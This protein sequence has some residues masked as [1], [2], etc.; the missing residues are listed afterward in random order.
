MT[1]C[2]VFTRIGNRGQD[3]YAFEIP[4]ETKVA[5]KDISLSDNYLDTSID[6]F[7][8]SKTGRTGGGITNISQKKGVLHIDVDAFSFNA[9]YKL[10][11]GKKTYTAEDFTDVKTDWADKFEAC[12]D[13][14]V[15]YRLY[16]PGVD[17]PRPLILFL[18]GGGEG[19]YDNWR[20]LTGCYGPTALAEHYP[21]CYVMAPQAKPGTFKMGGKRIIVGDFEGIEQDPDS[22]WSRTYLAEICDIIR[23]MIKAGKVDPERVYVTGLSM[24]GGGTLRCLNVGSDLFA[25]AAPICPTMTPETFK[26]LCGL[27]HTKIWISAAY[28]DH[29]IY[30]HKYLV[31]GIL[32]LRDAGNNDA[33]LTLYSPEELAKY[34]IGII[35]DMTYEA[36]F[37]WNH[38]CWVLTYHD[39]HGIMSWML[40]QTKSGK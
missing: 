28:V 30:R 4:C 14:E 10:K 19:G 22:G 15:L 38:T 16:K 37:G 6:V 24:G 32:A 5:K 40:N 35:E 31:D 17:V 26:I 36:R 29:T 13:G 1:D 20:Q 9:P 33:K 11:V 34:D 3:I 8:R 25:A 18:H 23:K 2:T 21:D 7:L 39:E 12:S 27:T